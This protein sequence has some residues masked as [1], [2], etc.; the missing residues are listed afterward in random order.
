MNSL[1]NPTLCSSLPT[2]PG[3]MPTSPGLMPPSPGLMPPSLP[4]SPGLTIEAP[5]GRM[6]HW[7]VVGLAVGGCGGVSGEK[8]QAAR[9]ASSVVVAMPSA[10]ASAVARPSAQPS[11]MVKLHY[12]SVGFDA[13]VSSDDRLLV[14][15]VEVEPLG[16]GLLVDDLTQPAA[17]PRLLGLGLSLDSAS[18][19]SPTRLL[20]FDS[21]AGVATVL[22]LDAGSEARTSCLLAPVATADGKR[23]A[24]IDA[25][26]HLV[27]LDPL[28]LDVQWRLEAPVVPPKASELA[29]AF[30]AGDLLVA[31]YDSGALVVNPASKTVLFQSA[32]AAALSGPLLSH[33]G[34][35]L[36]RGVCSGA[37]LLWTLSI[38]ELTSGA[39]VFSRNEKS[40][41]KPVFAF[42]RDEATAAISFAPSEV[43]V[44]SL[45]SGTERRINTGINY[46]TEAYGYLT[47]ALALTEDGRFVCGH[48]ATTIGKYTDCVNVIYAAYLSA[49]TG[50]RVKAPGFRPR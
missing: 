23:L 8:P 27:L 4:P 33:N 39:T 28:T 41:L 25:A 16:R 48:P 22:A 45:P 47:D 35:Y 40:G 6:T 1:A 36:A 3:L 17:L 15:P 20:G 34:R 2:S 44:V 14:R 29:L 24:T 38:V 26:G 21:R 11:G 10:A 32:N 49:E 43:I 12:K 50:T 18:F 30:G 42:S 31:S 5:T 7:L 13:L 37:D 19:V 9:P 46:D